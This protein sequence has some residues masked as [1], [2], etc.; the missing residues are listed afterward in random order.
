[1]DLEADYLKAGLRG[2][3]AF[4]SI[5]ALVIVDM[6][7]AYLDPNSSLFL[8]TAAPALSRAIL[9]AE[10]FAQNDQLIVFTRVEYD[11]DMVGAGLFVQKVPALKA[12]KTGSELAELPA[13]LQTFKKACEVKKQYASAFFGTSLSSLLQSN[14]VDTLMICGF[15]TS[16]CVRATAVDALQHGFAPFVV[17]DACADRADTIHQANLFDL[18]SKYAELVSTDE[19]LT[20]LSNLER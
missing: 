3:L 1:M 18:S 16:G 12:F 15:S 19:A 8:E 5:P 4:G 20:H 14:K 2:K 6:V 9:L 17:S 10:K 7:Q 11:Q 13:H